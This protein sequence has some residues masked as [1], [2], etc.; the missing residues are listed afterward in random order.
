M[1]SENGKS[2]KTFLIVLGIIM[3]FIGI[4]IP[5]FNVIALIG[6]VCII[7][8]ITSGKYKKNNTFEENV[9]SNIKRS[10]PVDNI[11]VRLRSEESHGYIHGDT[12]NVTATSTSTENTNECPICGDFSADGYCRKCGFR[13]RR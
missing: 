5:I 1:K 9:V 13:Y 2:R 12:E 10:M 3:M 7:N 8:G 11:Q 4:N 6:F